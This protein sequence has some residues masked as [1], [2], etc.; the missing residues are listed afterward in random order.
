MKIDPNNMYTTDI[1]KSNA[2]KGNGIVKPKDYEIHLTWNDATTIRAKEVKMFW[3]KNLGWLKNWNKGWE[4]EL[5]EKYKVKYDDSENEQ[6]LI[7]VRWERLRNQIY[8]SYPMY[9]CNTTD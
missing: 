3:Q 7:G 6:A 5:S 1:E 9:Y 2:A 4:N 8:S